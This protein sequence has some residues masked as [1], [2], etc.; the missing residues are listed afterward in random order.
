MYSQSHQLYGRQIA[1]TIL[2]QLKLALQEWNDLEGY[3]LRDE[4]WHLTADFERTRQYVRNNVTQSPC[5][6]LQ[7]RDVICDEGV[8]AASEFTPR[9]NPAETSIRA[10]IKQGVHIDDTK[11]NLYDPPD[12]YFP[13]LDAPDGEVDV[14]SIIE[15]GVDY[16]PNRARIKALAGE[17]DPLRHRRLPEAQRMPITSGLEPGQGWSLDTKS[18][19]ENCDGSYD[20]YCGRSADSKCLLYAHNDFRGGLRFD[21]LSG[22]LIVN[23]AKVKHGLVFVRMEHWQGAYANPNTANWKC[24]NGKTDCP[25]ARDERRLMPEL[26]PRRRLKDNTYCENWRFEFAVDGKVTSWTHEQWNSKLY[27]A[28]RVAHFTTLLDDAD[29]TGGQ[30]KDVEI[31]IRMT[32][33]ARDV[34]FLL[35][36]IYWL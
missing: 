30:E 29:Y 15:N 7:L 16:V 22:W 14:L 4:Q 27:G 6:S 10:I 3:E 31:A 19:P 26:L 35:S 23:L 2:S 34:T 8:Y 36:H 25:A 18:A 33:C 20:S 28:Q 9:Y 1:Y 11:P 24:E 17:I 12:A 21:G 5:R 32:G 13:A